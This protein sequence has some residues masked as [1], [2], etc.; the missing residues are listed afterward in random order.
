MTR[1]RRVRLRT[2]AARQVWDGREARGGSGFIPGIRHFQAGGGAGVSGRRGPGRRGRRRPA[3]GDRGVPRRLRTVA[4]ALAPRP[5]RIRVG[6]VGRADGRRAARVLVPERQAAA[7]PRARDPASGRTDRRL[8]RRLRGHGGGHR[9]MPGGGH[10]E[11]APRVHPGPTPPAA[12]ADGAWLRRRSAA[13]AGCGTAENGLRTG[14]PPSRGGSGMRR[15]VAHAIGIEARMGRDPACRGSVRSTR[16]RPPKGDRPLLSRQG[17]TVRVGRRRCRHHPPSRRAGNDPGGGFALRFGHCGTDSVSRGGQAVEGREGFRSRGAGIGSERW[18][19]GRPTQ[20]ELSTSLWPGL[21]GTAT[22][23]LLRYRFVRHHCPRQHKQVAAALCAA[24]T[25]RAR[26]GPSL[27]Q[28]TDSL[29]D[30]RFSG[31]I[32]TGESR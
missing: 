6:G 15:P 18:K 25:I 17:T 3:R 1:R 24:M 20:H 12:H 30:F 16:A 27:P 10:R 4:G 13:N 8:R 23:R 29:R 5:R 9:G 7:H 32:L 14:G 2:I 19:A 11:P 22:L 28:G 31:G 21:A 26:H